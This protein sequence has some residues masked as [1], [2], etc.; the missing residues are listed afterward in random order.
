MDWLEISVETDNEAAEAVSELM[1]RYARGG[2]A[3]ETPVDRFEYE[4]L[5]APPPSAVIVKAYLPMDDTTEDL[6]QRLEEGLWHL[7]QAYPI[8]EPAIRT[9]AEEDWSEA[10][11]RQYHR[12]RVGRGIVI[13]P[14]WKAYTPEPGETIV[15]MEPGMAF[16]T[17]LHP[18]TRLCLLALE[19]RLA[20]GAT[21]LDVGTGSGI[22]AIAAAQLGAG[23]VLAI[24]ADLAAVE[25]AGENV[26]MNKVADQVHVRHASLPGG[27][28]RQYGSWHLS[29]EGSLETLDTGQYDLVLVN[30]LAPVIIGM[31]PSLVGRLAAGGYVIAAGLIDSQR[32]AVVGA[33]EA[34]GLHTV[35]EKQEKDWVC[36]VAEVQ[37]SVL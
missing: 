27:M 17:G 8:P 13:V 21:V 24:D 1:N 35:E 2:V 19:E 10:W 34:E 16:G 20:P 22:L 26:A 9:L 25:V 6:R 31:A 29:G 5:E 3:I 33:L 7:A 11:K 23:S 12:L 37:R 28:T 15:R 32:D 36:L 30:I 4:L 14:A 18:T